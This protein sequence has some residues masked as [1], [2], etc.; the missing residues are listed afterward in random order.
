MSVFTNE[1]N[2]TVK[3]LFKKV[4]KVYGVGGDAVFDDGVSTS[5]PFDEVTVL[6]G[7]SVEIGDVSW[8]KSVTL[9]GESSTRFES[10]EAFE[11]FAQA[12]TQSS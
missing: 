8:S 12:G 7:D 3:V 4:G 9:T 2:E 6:A 10:L 11:A 1:T 5:Y